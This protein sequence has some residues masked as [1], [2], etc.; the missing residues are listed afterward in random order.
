VDFFSNMKAGIRLSVSER[1]LYIESPFGKY[2][3][4]YHS[5]KLHWN[6]PTH[7]VRALALYPPWIFSQRLA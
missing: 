1:D 2:Q 6:F 7:L 4:F 3:V 5:N